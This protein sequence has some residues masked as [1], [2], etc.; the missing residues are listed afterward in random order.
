MAIAELNS[1][2]DRLFNGTLIMLFILGFIPLVAVCKTFLDIGDIN[3]VFIYSTFYLLALFGILIRNKLDFT[4][5][6]RFL[7]IL[8]FLL[9][10]IALY[11]VGLAGAGIYYLVTFCVLTSVMMGLRTGIA[12]LMISLIALVTIAVLS[13][14]GL[15]EFEEQ[16]MHDPSSPFS[17]IQA[18]TI[19]LMLTSV[20]VVVPGR[21]QEKL[22]SLLN[23][24]GKSRQEL[25]LSNQRLSDEVETR[26]KTEKRLKRSQQ[27]L[28]SLAS[29]LTLVE[30]N[31]RRRIATLL[32]DGI[33][34]TLAITNIKLKM[35]CEEMP[36]RESAAE[37][38]GI[39]SL[40]DT[41]IDEARTLTFDLNPPA[42]YEYK[43]EEALK[44]LFN[45]YK[46]TL[47]LDGAFSVQA[48]GFELDEDVR[49]LLFHI[50]RE[51]LVNI[52]KHSGASRMDGSIS[53]T[54]GRIDIHI[55]DDGK[56]FDPKELE[57]G[58]SSSGFGIFS[59]RERLLHFN[60][61]LDIESAAGAGCQIHISLEH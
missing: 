35:L 24:L 22:I 4:K 40:I 28:R 52:S 15:L 44:W 33:G 26:K 23:R 41:T 27:Q 20:M 42:L 58:G 31:E 53:K 10:L 9:G 55:S 1:L 5:R 34:Q 8:F 30:S 2:R 38:T 54:N 19:F 39:C 29:R 12:S 49:I 11:R 21:L 13:V 59:I 47:N 43:F 7:F 56:G 16:L 37:L 51:L 6:A 18:I 17:W 3:A 57:P 61:S 48:P 46:Q 60:G 25:E 32:H 14:H 50:Y 36:D 45:R